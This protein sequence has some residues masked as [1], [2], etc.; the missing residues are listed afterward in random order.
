[1]RA[2]TQASLSLTTPQPTTSI[3]NSPTPSQPPDGTATTPLIT[4]RYTQPPLIYNPGEFYDYYARPGDTLDGV[5]GRFGVDPKEISSAQP[6]LAIGYLPHGQKLLI[7][8]ALELVTA[9]DP[10]LPDSELVYSPSARDFDV[11]GFVNAAGGYLSTYK[12]LVNEEL[13]SGVQIV[14]RVADQLS[15]N[16]RLLLA[17]LEYRAG[18]VYDKTASPEELVYPLGFGIEGRTGLYQEM[19]IA[20]TQLNKAYY[21]WR[22]GTFTEIRY[23]DG[24]RGRLNPQLNAG[25]AA[26]QHLFAMFH[27]PETWQRALYGEESFP[28][29]YQVMLGDYWVRAEAAEP[30][31]PAGLGQPVLELPFVAGELWSM[32]AGPHEA[33]NAGTPRGAL[34]FSPTTGGAI[35]AVSSAWVTASA[36]G[37]VVRAANNTVALDLDGDGY[38]GS[39]WVLIYLHLAQEGLVDEGKHVDLD[40]PLG[41]PSCEGGKATGKHVHMARKYNGEWLLA[42]GPV[43]FVLSGWFPRADERDYHG[44]LVRGDKIVSSDINGGRTSIITR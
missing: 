19:M 35:C 44:T 11:E 10:L 3:E 33:W 26:L 15:V 13:L 9:P 29:R 21:G 39:G 37:V 32:T 8:N 16:P 12:G 24:T 38:E 20:A 18:W 22:Q 42:D 17:I 2:S 23:N 6:L 27:K 34:D 14:Q 5:A 41:H 7:P 1:M 43:P 31:I 25:S 36:P 4:P 30:L 28:A 40:D